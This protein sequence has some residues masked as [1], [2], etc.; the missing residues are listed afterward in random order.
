MSEGEK[1]AADYPMAHSARS[2]HCS[3]K[4]SFSGRMIITPRGGGE[5]VV[6]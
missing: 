4:F 3:L 2:K 1:K 6:K 5:P